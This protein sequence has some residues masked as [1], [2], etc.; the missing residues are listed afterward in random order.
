MRLKP[1]LLLERVGERDVDGDGDPR[2]SLFDP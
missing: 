2:H 1:N